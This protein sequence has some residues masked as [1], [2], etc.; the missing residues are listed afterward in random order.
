MKFTVLTLF[1]EQFGGF[2]ST[3]IIKRALSS[4]LIHIELVN[5]RDYSSDRHRSVDDKPYGGGPG[6]LL[7]IDVVVKALES[8]LKKN[9]VPRQATLVILTDPAAPVLTQAKVRRFKQNFRHLIIICGHYEGIDARISDYIN[10][11]V[12]LGK[13]VLTGGEI[14][15]MALID[16]VTR[17]VPGTLH[18]PLSNIIESFSPGKKGGE[19]PQFTKP[20]I[21]RGKSVPAVLLSG[22][23]EKI[24]IWK[25][26]KRRRK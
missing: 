2:T 9:P 11:K 8:V 25:E 6:M 16:A 15:A 7:R 12:S 13:Y 5:I 17:L 21:F 22:N 26:Q 10:L 3:S 24:K 20:R 23:H 19:F 4:G 1:P 18:H 14:P